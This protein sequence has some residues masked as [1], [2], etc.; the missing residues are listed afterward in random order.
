M[1]RAAGTLVRLALAACAFLAACTLAGPGGPSATAPGA[2]ISVTPLAPPGAAPPAGT[3]PAASQDSPVAPLAGATPTP[4]PPVA[5][6]QGETPGTAEAAPPPPPPLSPEALACQRGGG[7]WG[8][9]PAGGSVCLRTTRDAG[10][11][12]TRGTQCEGLCLA[13]SGTCAPITPVFG[14]NDIFQDDGS[15]VT[16]CLD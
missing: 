13:R 6:A 3:Q 8:K 7:T 2:A 11:S 9:T 14:C 4:P 5:E 12:C 16:L 15:R 1:A 10:K